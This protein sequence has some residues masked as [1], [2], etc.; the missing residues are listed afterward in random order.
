MLRWS[1]GR[2]VTSLVVEQ[3]PALGR[4]EQAGDDVEQGGLAAAG[5][6]EQGIGA[7]IVPVEVE[8]LQRPVVLGFGGC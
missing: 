4:P 7:A 2:S 6:A 5:G 1:G 3:D 8:P